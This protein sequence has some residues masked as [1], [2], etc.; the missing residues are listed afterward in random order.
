MLRMSSRSA[1]FIPGLR[2]T[3]CSTRWWERPQHLVGVADEIAIGEE[4][5]LDDVPHRLAGR[6]LRRNRALGQSGIGGLGL[7]S[8]VSH[9]DIFW[10]YVTKTVSLTKGSC[11]NGRFFRDASTRHPANRSGLVIP[12]VAWQRKVVE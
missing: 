5:Q 4:Q 9:V 10:F 11:R 6:G 1:T 3:K 8:Y 7:H 12:S 2:L